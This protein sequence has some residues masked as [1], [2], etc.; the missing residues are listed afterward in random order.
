MDTTMLSIQAT[1]QAQKAD[2]YFTSPC[3][4]FARKVTVE[5]VAGSEIVHFPM[6]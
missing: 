5:T 2:R 3:K 1:V 6:G 4:H